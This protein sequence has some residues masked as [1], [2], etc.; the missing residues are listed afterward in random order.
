MYFRIFGNSV[1]YTEKEIEEGLFFC[2]DKII[3][4]DFL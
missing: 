2:K 1:G 4:V 3:L